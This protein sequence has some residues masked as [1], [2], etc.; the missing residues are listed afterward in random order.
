M[1]R[2]V[3]SVNALGRVGSQIG[4]RRLCVFAALLAVVYVERFRPQRVDQIGFQT[5]L[6]RAGEPQQD[7]AEAIAHF[8]VLVL[9]DQITHVGK[10]LSAFDDHANLDRFAS[11][12]GGILIGR[13]DIAPEQGFSQG[14]Q[15]GGVASPGCVAGQT[16]PSVIDALLGGDDRIDLRLQCVRLNFRSGCFCELCFVLGQFRRGVGCFLGG[17]DLC[18]GRS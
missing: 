9:S 16:D 13:H 11:D 10:D 6:H 17:A 1:T 14:R 7:A 3:V 15:V 4:S 18:G 12:L 2:T 8:L 5:L